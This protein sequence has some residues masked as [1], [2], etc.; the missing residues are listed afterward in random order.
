M[1]IEEALMKVYLEHFT[2]P[3]EQEEKIIDIAA[4]RNGGP[5]PYIDNPYPCGIFREKELS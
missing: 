2:L 5:L 3:V 1:Y 4:A